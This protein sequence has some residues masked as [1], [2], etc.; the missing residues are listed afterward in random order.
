MLQ[1]KEELSYGKWM[2]L[3]MLRSRQAS[4]SKELEEG[5]KRAMWCL[6]EESFTDGD[7]C[8]GV[9]MGGCLVL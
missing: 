3:G 1:R 4:M 7:P 8:P 5:R 9:E 6:R 2:G